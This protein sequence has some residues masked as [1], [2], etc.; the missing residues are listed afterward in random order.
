MI[1]D[2]RNIATAAIFERRILSFRY[3]GELKS[4]EPY[5]VG[6]DRKRLDLRVLAFDI[7]DGE[8]HGFQD[9]Y[10]AHMREVTLAAKNFVGIRRNYAPRDLSTTTVHC[11]V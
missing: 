5:L 6:W 11:R 1:M 7:T 9:F 4:V 8:E 3:R 2:I 10:A